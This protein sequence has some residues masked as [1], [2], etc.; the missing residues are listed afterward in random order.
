MVIG[1]TRRITAIALVVV[2][3]SLPGALVLLADPSAELVAALAAA[4]SVMVAVWLLKLVLEVEQSERQ[5]ATTAE[6]ILAD[7]MNQICTLE[8]ETKSAHSRHEAQI[9]DLT[10]AVGR[11][12]TGVANVDDQR[13]VEMHRRDLEIAEITLTVVALHEVVT[14]ASLREQ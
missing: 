11:L 13:R 5:L 1:R 14:G 10:D 9:R 8:A 2:I 4:C 3:A 12:E 7:A 6:V